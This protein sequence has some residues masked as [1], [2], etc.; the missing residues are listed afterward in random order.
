MERPH[1]SIVGFGMDRQER[2]YYPTP[3]QT[4]EALFKGEIFDG[5]V[6]ECACGD[7]RMS[8]VIKKYNPVFST[9]I[10]PQNYG[11][12][13]IDFLNPSLEISKDN[14]ITNPPFKFA[15]RFVEIGKKRA[16]KKIALLL[17][18]VFLEGIGRHKM[19]Q[20]TEFP[21]SKVYVFC[22]R[23]PIYKDGI[24]LKNS[25]LIAFAW[26]VWDRSYIGKP[27]IEWINDEVNGI[28]PKD[29]SLGILP[30]V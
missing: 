15:E 13:Q 2:D 21:L 17:K 7:G 5:E 24:V 10:E 26:F 20:D 30:T 1:N 18:L 4:T 3:P 16:K 11:D 27:T 8:E 6:W 22:R 12:G 25:G 23:Q 29:K 14:I 28:P 19:F 9:D